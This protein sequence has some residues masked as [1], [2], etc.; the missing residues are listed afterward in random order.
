[1]KYV[2]FVKHLDSVK[3]VY[4]L[5]GKESYYVDLILEDILSRL[6]KSDEERRE[7]ITKFDCDNKVEL[8]EI[9]SALETPPFFLDK[10][11]VIVKNATIFKSKSNDEESKKNSLDRLM[12]VLSNMLDTNYVIFITNEVADKRRKIYKLVDKIGL[13]LESE[14][15]RVWEIESWLSLTLRNLNKSMNEEAKKYF[16]E[17]VSVLPEIS[18]HYLDNELKKVALYVEG[19]IIAKKDLQLMMAEP[20]EVSVFAL[21]NAISSKNISKAMYLLKSQINEKKEIPLIALLARN[22]RLMIRIK[23][24]IKQGMREKEVAEILG[25]NFYVAKKTVEDSKKYSLW[26]LEE[27]FL[28]LADVDYFYKFGKAGSEMLERII[29]KLIQ[30]K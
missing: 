30:G 13:I 15:L 18:L 27:V 1:M 4:L 22:V 5:S 11:V 28:M 19:K 8:G 21:M 26:L 23:L 17:T 7:G 25:L 6:F 3:N 29:L 12:R 14:P 20:P 16:L 2:D 10:V 9:I 24:Y